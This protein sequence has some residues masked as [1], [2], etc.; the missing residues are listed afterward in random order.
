MYIENSVH[1]ANIG[2]MLE[3]CMCN[4]YNLNLLENF[5][6]ININQ[7]EGTSVVA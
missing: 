6:A 1:V 5:I 3:N 4:I 7:S 2:R